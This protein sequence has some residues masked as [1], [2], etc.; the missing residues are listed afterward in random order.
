VLASAGRLAQTLGSTIKLVP[1]SSRVSA[2]GV[3]QTATKGRCR[4]ATGLSA[5]Q[6]SSQDEACR[7][8]KTGY[9]SRDTCAADSRMSW[10]ALPGRRSFFAGG[11]GLHSVRRAVALRTTVLFVPGGGGASKTRPQTFVCVEWGA[12]QSG[13]RTGVS[14]PNPE[15]GS[16]RHSAA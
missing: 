1:F 7:S 2:F 8:A 13:S 16:P 15:L 3:S 6:P 4:K 5:P 10:A 9:L 11:A 12:L 14:F